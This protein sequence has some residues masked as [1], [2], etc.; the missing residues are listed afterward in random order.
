MLILMGIGVFFGVLTGCQQDL[1]IPTAPPSKDPSEQWQTLMEQ[2]TSDAGIDWNHLEANQ[3]SIILPTV[4]I[5]SV[6]ISTIDQN[7]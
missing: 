7:F 3:P 2:S 4:S 1:P 5:S 6:N